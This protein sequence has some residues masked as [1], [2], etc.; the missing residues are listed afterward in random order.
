M[1]VNKIG[2]SDKD[3]LM[4]IKDPQYFDRTLGHQLSETQGRQGQEVDK[5]ADTPP[6]APPKGARV[7]ML[8]KPYGD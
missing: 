6:L 8:G 5:G 3:S 4:L 7:F 2:D 1:L